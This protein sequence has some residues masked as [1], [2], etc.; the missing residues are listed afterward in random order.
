M[1]RGRI[2]EQGVPQKLLDSP[3]HE[4]TRCLVTATP[5]SIMTSRI[6]GA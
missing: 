4:A 5:Q 1:N 3:E 6:L 2:V